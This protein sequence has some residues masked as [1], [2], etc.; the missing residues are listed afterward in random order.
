MMKTAGFAA[1]IA[2]GF[3][4]VFLLSWRGHEGASA[5]WVFGFLAVFWS[6]IM[7]LRLLTLTEPLVLPEA[8][9]YLAHKILRSFREKQEETRRIILETAFGG[10]FLLFMFAGVFFAVWQIYCA[11]FPHDGP[12]LEGFAGMVA[13]FF[14]SV[15]R[16]AAAVG[17]S[18]AQGLFFGWGHWF[19]LFLA[20]CM[21]GFVLRSFAAERSMT[22]PAL[23]ILSSYAVAG[24]IVC[25]G[26]K[27][28]GGLTVESAALT[29]SGAG[30]VSY[31]LSTL[32]AGKS[33][34]LFDIMLLES[35]VVGL[36]LL[37]FLLFV[38]LGSI[39]LTAG[40]GRG[41]ALMTTAGLLA[42]IALI[43]CFF[44]AFSPPV[45]GT[46]ALAA[47]AVLLSWGAGE[48]ALAA[49]DS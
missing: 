3:F 7:M 4:S 27:E 22:R 6:L 5:D 42:G 49:L 9:G 45:A 17:G 37:T 36:G 23:I 33:L 34:S 21:M 31:L 8:S 26:L 39:A 48:P 43:L 16:D 29:G 20:F 1:V 19:L 28:G 18:F 40:Q 13:A 25:A 44:L 10:S 12:R 32:P 14:E 41:G 46:M 35:G 30:T 2:A 15:P 38:P 24:A 11:A 47:M